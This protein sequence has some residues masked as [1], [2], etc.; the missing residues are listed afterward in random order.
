MNCRRLMRLPS[1]PTLHPTTFRRT[2][3]AASQGIIPARR[4]GGRL[5]QLFFRQSSK[6]ERHIHSLP[7]ISIKARLGASCA[8]HSGSPALR[9][10]SAMR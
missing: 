7:E 3:A 1:E 2:E 9:K 10:P 6:P 4:R 5:K 8:V